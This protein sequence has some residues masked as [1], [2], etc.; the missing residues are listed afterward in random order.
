MHGAFTA[1]DANCNGEMTWAD[2][3]N[4]ANNLSDG[5]CG[6]NDGSVPGDWRVPNVLELLSLVDWRYSDPALSNAEGTGKWSAGSSDEV[7]I[8]VQ[9]DNYWSSTTIASSTGFAWYVYFYNGD[10]GDDDKE[11]Q[12][13]FVWPVRGG[14]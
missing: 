8:S 14:N 5:N 4:W 9:A 12:S 1:D 13:N 11:F 10:V 2:A 6:L 7:F 3:L